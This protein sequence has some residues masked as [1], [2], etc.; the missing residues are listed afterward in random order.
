VKRTGVFVNYVPVHVVKMRVKG[1]NLITECQVLG[2]LGPNVGDVY[3]IRV[4]RLN[5]AVAEIVEG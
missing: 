2:Y 4:S 3:N 1:K 5:P